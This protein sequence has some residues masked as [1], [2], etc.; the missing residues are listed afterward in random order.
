MKKFITLF[1]LLAGLCQ[2]ATAQKGSCGD[3]VKWTLSGETLVISGSGPMTEY[4][5][6]TRPSWFPYESQ[7]KHIEVQEG[8]TTIGGF[9]FYQSP[10]V[11]TLT[12][13]EGLTVI[14]DHAFYG[15]GALKSINLPS[16]LETFYGGYSSYTNYGYCFS[17]C[18][19]LTEVTIP[20]SVKDLG[21]RTFKHCIN[22]RK[23]NWN[24]KQTDLRG[25]HY[26]MFSDCPVHEV[27]FG[28]SVKWVPEYLFYG[29]GALSEITTPGT[30][31][32]VGN[33]AFH[34]TSWENMPNRENPLYIDKALYKYNI[35]EG[36]AFEAV[37]PEGITG[38]TGGTF[39]DEK[40][41]VKITIPSTMKLI[42]ADAFKGC[43]SLGSV[44]WNAIDCDKRDNGSWFGDCAIYEF[45]FSPEVRY[46][47]GGIL[48]D[49]SDL[50]D[51]T[52]PDS[53]VDV[54]PDSF[55]SCFGLKYIVIPDKVQSISW[56]VFDNTDLDSIYIGENVKWIGSYIRAKK[57]IW[58]VRNLE[59]GL[60]SGM[61]EVFRKD[62][63]EEVEFGDK[64]VIIPTVIFN[65]CPN[66]KSATFG[67][68]V[69]RIEDGAFEYSGLT[70]VWLNEG[71]EYLGFD[72][73][74]STEIHDILFPAS[75]KHNQAFR[76]NT[77]NNVV[78]LGDSVLSS[79]EIAINSET[80]VYAKRYDLYNADW[81][82]S[83]RTKLKPLLV[84]EQP[85]E[86][87]YNGEAFDLSSYYA[88][89]CN[90]PGYSVE[91]TPT[92][93]ERRPGKHKTKTQVTFKG[94][95]DFTADV[96]INY[97]IKPT[98]EISASKKELATLIAETDS[99][100]NIITDCNGN[101][102]EA[103]NLGE[104]HM[105][106]NAACKVEGSDKFT[107]W[108]VLF[109]SEED[110]EENF[111]DYGNATQFH[112]DYSG[113]DSSDG[114][115]H[116]IGFH[117]PQGIKA[118]KI[119]FNYTTRWSGALHAPTS[120]TLLASADGEH[121]DNIGIYD[122]ELPT[123]ERA[124]FVSN[125]IHTFADYTD[126]R[127][128]VHS[129]SSNQYWG[130]HAIFV[131][132]KFGVDYVPANDQINEAFADLSEN[133][134]TDARNI[135]SRAYNIFINPGSEPDE[136]NDQINALTVKRDLLLSAVENVV[137]I[138]DITMD[139]KT[140]APMYNLLGTRV[141]NAKRPGIYVRQGRKVI[142]R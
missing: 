96:D 129:S 33:E 134:L 98:E 108:S 99:L 104:E 123:G 67:K 39:K 60:G 40:Y 95:K 138:N 97:T 78:L 50:E 30:I 132:S 110:D 142:M 63:L 141:N 93:S 4:N 114:L 51:V 117:I 118:S 73:F 113:D 52:L 130:G 49:C 16:T 61:T 79:W 105:Y 102:W 70:E 18:P 27:V 6:D 54:G 43:T 75:V 20:E 64:A 24:A 83:S 106:T 90:L 44:H 133:D 48:K 69:K 76:H 72:C 88:P 31:E 116:Y 42:G 56:S 32:Y 92:E 35:P 91:V 19:S 11:E 71:I 25:Y 22:L 115:D 66:L 112:S 86:I 136:I 122:E 9:S 21:Y 26:E 65:R 81:S 41:L 137:K 3:N 127:V 82:W 120:I 109:D 14:G 74:G 15:C 37:I 5:Y 8:V 2:S 23:V 139:A 47:K 140:D 29:V 124:S 87:E 125:S 38:I 101:N 53:L 7:I 126:F 1:F 131:M 128:M 13:A 121:W 135:S 10:A 28:S 119:K 55:R 89:G 68:S 107:D 12:I 45:I 62:E 85:V 59:W 80:N 17:E 77:L 84:E 94:V 103:M 34:G 100:I 57:V 58:N 36:R 111:E 46:L